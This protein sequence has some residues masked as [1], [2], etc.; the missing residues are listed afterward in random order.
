MLFDFM[1]FEEFVKWYTELGKLK[2]FWAK[3]FESIS[4]LSREDGL[5]SCWRK[6]DY[7]K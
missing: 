3:P 2:I 4:L 6:M 7:Q 5:V 1:T